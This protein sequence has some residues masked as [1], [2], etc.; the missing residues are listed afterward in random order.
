MKILI[1]LKK[2][3][4]CRK[5]IYLVIMLLKEPVRIF[6]RALLPLIIRVKKSKI[7]CVNIL[8]SRVSCVADAPVRYLLIH[9]VIGIHFLILKANG[10]AV[11]GRAVVNHYQLNFI[12]ADGLINKRKNC[13]L[14][15][16]LYVIYR[17][18][19]RKQ[20]FMFL[21][22]NIISPT[23]KTCALFQSAKIHIN[24]NTVASY[25]QHQYTKLLIIKKYIYGY[26]VCNL[27]KISFYLYYYL[28]ISLFLGIIVT[29]NL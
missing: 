26:F 15:V 3:Y 17:H 29:V 1:R 6:K 9:N 25:F 28:N 10:L 12:K 19:Y 7:L 13:L 5:N 23:I 4:S 27:S 21:L 2:L 14:N 11:V 22:H 18:N 8:K 16:I 24:D 20:I